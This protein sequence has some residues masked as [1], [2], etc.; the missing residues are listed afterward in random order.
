MLLEG[1]K[2]RGDK[3]LAVFKDH[4]SSGYKIENG[5]VRVFEVTV[6]QFGK[7]GREMMVA[8]LR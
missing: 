8:G 3:K 5:W 7:L 2:P 4:K 1:F 6:K